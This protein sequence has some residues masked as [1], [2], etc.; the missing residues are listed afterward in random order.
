MK[1]QFIRSTVVA[2]VV[3]VL[4]SVL[5]MNVSFAVANEMTSDT[6]AESIDRMIVAYE[7][8][9][10]PEMAPDVATGDDSITQDVTLSPGDYLGGGMRTVEISETVTEDEALA[11]AAELTADPR[12]KWAEPDA[13]MKPVVDIPG[14][15]AEITQSPETKK[16]EINT[17]SVPNPEAVV[18]SSDRRQVLEDG[19]RI[20]TACDQSTSVE[21]IA[22]CFNDS[23]L[24]AGASTNAE[25]VYSDAYVRAADTTQLIVESVP[26]AAISDP[27]WLL[28]SDTYLANTFDVNGDGAAE[29]TVIPQW[30]S[31]ASNQST[32][33]TILDWDGTSWV[34]RSSSCT[35]GTLTRKLGDH[36]AMSGTTNSWWQMSLSWSCVFGNETSNVRVV[37]LLEDSLAT[38]LS[39]DNFVGTAMNFSAL[40]PNAPTISTV[41]PS[42]GTTA[43][44]T[45]VTITGTNLSA[46]TSVTFGTVSAP[47][48]SQTSSSVVVT[49]PA[50][51]AG[52][53]NITVTTPDGSAT[54]TGGFTYQRPEGSV[55]VTVTNPGGSVTR[56]GG[57]MYTSPIAPS[58][59]SVT[60][61]A[62]PVEGGTSL[63]I[64]GTGLG[65]ATTV[66]VGDSDATINSQ[67]STEIIATTPPGVSGVFAVS[68]SNVMGTATRDNSF[69]YVNAPVLSGISVASGSTAGGL[70]LILSG[71]DLSAVTAVTVGGTAATIVT[72]TPT[73]LTIISPAHAAGATSITATSPGGTSTLADSFNY[74]APATITTLGTSSGST[75]GGTTVAINGTNLA[76]TSAVTIGGSAAAIVS[77]DSTQLTITTA[78]HASGL[79]SLVVTTPAGSVT[80]LNSFTFI[81]PVK[82]AIKSVSPTK[83][84]TLGGTTVTITGTSLADVSRV[85]F[86]GTDA[87]ITSRSATRLILQTPAHATGVVNIVVTNP[88]GSTTKTSG[89]TFAVLPTLSGLS[90]QAG[91]L[92]AGARVTLTGTNLSTAT[93]VTFGG[94]AAT[95]VSKSA[96][97]LVVTAPARAA[98]TVSVMVTTPT[99]S[100]TLS[101]AYTFVAL[102]TIT[103]TPS[104]SSGSSA[105]GTTVTITGTNLSRVTRVTF[106]GAVATIQASTA[107]TVRVTAPGHSTGR[108]SVIVTSPGGTASRS[109]AFI[110]TVAPAVVK[111]LATTSPTTT[112]AWMKLTSVAAPSVTQFSPSTALATGG[113]RVTITGTRLTGANVS[114]GGTNA[115]VLSN[116]GS[117]LVVST[118]ALTTGAVDLVISTSGGSFTAPSALTLVAA[119]PTITNISPAT[120]TSAGG[121]TVVITG[122]NLDTVTSTTFGG[123]AATI[124]SRTETTLTVVTPAAAPPLT[125]P[126]DPYY[127]NGNLW[128]L[129]GT[130]GVNAP[131]A[132]NRTQGSSDV[133]V[134]V[135]DTGILPHADNGQMVAGYDFVSENN[136]A[137]DGDGWDADPTDPGDWITAAED[138]SGF[139]ADCGQSDS[140]WHG[141]HVAGTIAAA[142]NNI[143]IVGV[144]P[145]VK[146]QPVRVLGKCGGY[147]SDI[148][149]GIYWASGISPSGSPENATPADVINMSLGGSGSC[150]SSM[151]TAINSANSRGVTVVVAAGNSNTNA[152]TGE[153]AN[154]DGV[155]V[156]GATDSLGKRASFS[157][158]GALVDVS[159]PG[160]GILST[161]NTGRTTSALDAYVSYNGTSMATP[162]VA[163]VVALMLSASPSLTPSEVEAR[164]KS[165]SRTFGSATCDANPLLL[166]GAGIVDA[167]SAM[168]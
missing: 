138:S 38:D 8:G 78:A 123:Q 141:T 93:A 130:Y 30:A 125:L 124:V 59:T 1:Y 81:S 102:P 26:W 67:T 131:E 39:P 116:N 160:V 167:G 90:P 129:S 55:D 52:F 57:Y 69:T 31:L 126:T 101:N 5:P 44:G 65:S 11:L 19:K 20:Q 80:K 89:F 35:A 134:A 100:V 18:K 71:T 14:G 157:N 147:T 149:A 166:C 87:T 110:Y 140:S 106:G 150:T 58:I 155:V 98:G 42:T 168:P 49:S 37:S 10:L 111:N 164:L 91:R 108:V 133:V 128:G 117:S 156:V 66:S 21:P 70:N 28:L 142:S 162:H 13:L 159:A 17:L 154:C 68:V 99:G 73:A 24:D 88:A 46:T 33:V 77:A 163:G 103:S 6:T 109:L 47:V 137:N 136:I 97:S 135:I 3:A 94:T 148:I 63:R 153:P 2:T 75:L 83:G 95:I 4:G 74:Y 36:R 104:P 72:Q 22:R 120:G 54:K 127:S 85:S 165:T 61:A 51:S 9:V 34:E 143:G 41:T 84:T 32:G 161:L 79:V 114:F 115:T 96:T 152:N 53:V 25:I 119:A 107:T 12:I 23:D 29:L 7:P 118:P 145:N 82:A 60:P 113:T 16:G 122:T 27:N 15:I 92:T 144:A 146:V 151:Q 50:G 121:E 158:Y 45:E 48:T 56:T 112:E 62:G 43:G 76:D 86:G 105:G 139:F 40:N 64:V 132:W